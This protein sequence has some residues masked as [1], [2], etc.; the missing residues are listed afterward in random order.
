LWLCFAK[1]SRT[2]ASAFI[3]FFYNFFTPPSQLTFGSGY[4]LL[5]KATLLRA[6]FAFSLGLMLGFASS[7]YATLGGEAAPL[8]DLGRM[9]VKEL[10]VFKD[11]HVFVDQHGSLPTDSSGNVL[12]DYLP[13]PVMGTFWPYSADKHVKL[14][15]AVASQRRVSVERTALTIRELLEANIGAEAIITEDITNHYSATILGIPTR[16]SDEL[17]RTS[18]PNS[19]EKLPVKGNIVLLKTTD[20]VKTVTIDRIQDVTFKEMKNATSKEEEFRNLLTLKLDWGKNKTADNADVGLLY[21]QKGVRWIPSYQVT[22]DGNSNAVIRLQATLINELMDFEDANVNLVVGVPTFAFK[23]SVD[24]VSLQQTAAQ[25]SQFFQTHPSGNLGNNAFGAN[26]SNSIMSQQAYRATEYRSSSSDQ[27]SSDSTPDSDSAR[28]EDLF[29]FNA[30][31]LTMKKGERMV[32]PIAE[33]TIPYE[34]V[35]ILDLPFSPPPELSRNSNNPQQMELAR[36]LNSPK[37]MHKIR[38]SNKSHYPLTTAPALILRDGKV[39]SQGMMT[40]TAIGSESDLTITTAVEISAKRSDVETGRKPDAMVIEG[41]HYVRVDLAGKITLANHRKQPAQ[42]EV[43]RYVL[44]NPE[45]ADR[46]GNV[47]KISGFEDGESGVARPDWYYYYGWPY[48]WNN[49]NSVGRITWKFK[50]DP[51]ERVDLGYK[52]NY[53]WR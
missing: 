23:D 26:F 6:S 38:L 10:T 47:E 40:Y 8:K 31:H 16:S 29:I 34:D 30:G 44:G 25:L 13:S 17:A 27:D 15:G 50:M 32:V 36:L 42:V 1:S 20:G 51:G 43:T 19:G 46:D 24:P 2:A 22:I 12:M 28:N 53:F 7:V 37:V 45:S 4:S 21:L 14:K 33:F 35:F 11:G 5:M 9:P 3:Q 18:P 49:F 39:L 41:N 52:W 48:W